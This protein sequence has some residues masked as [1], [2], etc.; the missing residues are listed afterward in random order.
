MEALTRRFAPSKIFKT[1]KE[2]DDSSGDEKANKGGSKKVKNLQ[3][4]KLKSNWPPHLEKHYNELSALY[5]GRDFKTPIKTAITLLHALNLDDAACDVLH[6]EHVIENMVIELKAKTMRF[7][8]RLTGRGT[9]LVPVF[10]LLVKLDVKAARQFHFLCDP[11]AKDLRAGTEEY[12]LIETLPPAQP[13]SDRKQAKRE[14]DLYMDKVKSTINGDPKAYATQLVLLI[15]GCPP[16][17]RDKVLNLLANV[18]VSTACR[19]SRELAAAVDG[20]QGMIPAE[21]GQV[22]TTLALLVVDINLA[23][24]EAEGPGKREFDFLQD[25]KI[26]ALFAKLEKGLGEQQFDLG[27]LIATLC[28]GERTTASQ[29]KFVT[30]LMGHLI[31]GAH[32]R[33]ELFDFQ[34]F[35]SAT[36]LSGMPGRCAKW[37]ANSAV[38][39]CRTAVDVGR[40]VDAIEQVGYMSGM[41]ISHWAPLGL[42][43]SIVGSDIGNSHYIKPH[44]KEELEHTGL[45]GELRKRLQDVDDNSRKSISLLAAGFNAVDQL[46]K[47]RERSIELATASHTAQRQAKEEKEQQRLQDALKSASVEVRGAIEDMGS[48]S[49]W[50]EMLS[51]AKSVSDKATQWKARRAEGCGGFGGSRHIG[52]DEASGRARGD[53]SS[54]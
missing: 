42:W 41:E 10:R 25:P 49:S 14:R 23:M 32:D 26:V 47:D 36:L 40:L 16:S 38:G 15:Q 5:P 54:G 28:P 51:C 6:D 44:I 11:A 17:A 50:D 8:E 22:D 2:D 53:S 52:R 31:Q 18:K 37:L 13:A 3:P 24:A 27:T 34:G 39:T 30:G 43:A 35:L 12:R 46:E 1:F 29:A 21:R 33:G 7:G 9:F 48:I 4:P 20:L 45:L 19:K